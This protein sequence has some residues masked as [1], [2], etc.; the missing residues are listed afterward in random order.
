VEVLPLPVVAVA[1]HPVTAS[2]MIAS[3]AVSRRIS[4]PA[5][6]FQVGQGLDAEKSPPV[7]PFCRSG[8]GTDCSLYLPH[9][10]GAVHSTGAFRVGQVKHGRALLV[11]DHQKRTALRAS[12]LCETYVEVAAFYA[13]KAAF[14]LV[15][16][17]TRFVEVR[18]A[19]SLSHDTGDSSRRC[20]ESHSGPAVQLTQRLALSGGSLPGDGE[21]VTA[22]V[23]RP[24]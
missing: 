18:E 7:P 3:P 11:L 16:A 17:I 9:R 15:R 1:A 8:R 10:V 13:R 6:R 24:G 14:T 21:A 23:Q 4:P 12:S 22:A 5:C 19:R 20:L 2:V